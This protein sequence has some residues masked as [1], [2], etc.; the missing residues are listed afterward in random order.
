MGRGCHA[1]DLLQ[2]A[3]DP[4]AHQRLD[5]V[6][7]DVDVRRPRDDRILQDAR[8]QVGGRPFSSRRP[9]RRAGRLRGGALQQLENI[10]PIEQVSPPDRHLRGE[11]GD[12]LE[13]GHLLDLR[14]R[15]LVT[16]VLHGQP[17]VAVLLLDR[18]DEPAARVFLGKDAERIG[19]DVTHLEVNEAHAPVLGELLQEEA[20]RDDTALGQRPVDG[21]PQARRHD[22]YLVEF[23]LVDEAQPFDDQLFQLFIGREH[24]SVPPAVRRRS[25]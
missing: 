17:E 4:A 23:G 6:G 9:C 22:P 18:D 21:K 20:H 3:V 10:P 2:H 16:R 25:R 7:L 14:D 13:A 11:E 19:L 12:D 24:G 5:F 1:Q 8:E 15:L